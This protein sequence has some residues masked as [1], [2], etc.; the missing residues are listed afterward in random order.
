MIELSSQF[1][2]C[3]LAAL[4][5]GA[6]TGTPHH[7]GFEPNDRMFATVRDD[8]EPDRLEVVKRFDTIVREFKLPCSRVDI[9]APEVLYR[10]WRGHHGPVFACSNGAVIQGALILRRGVGAKDGQ[11]ETSSEILETTEYMEPMDAKWLGLILEA[12]RQ[13]FHPRGVALGVRVDDETGAQEFCMVDDRHSAEGMFYGYDYIPQLERKF[14]LNAAVTAD[15][16]ME[17]R[18]PERLRRIGSVVQPLP[19]LRGDPDQ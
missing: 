11:T 16:M 15:E 14:M 10:H 7:I 17:Q 2:P 1:Y 6:E 4:R 5:R 12:N 3:V 13:F 19:E 9:D 8:Y 18:K